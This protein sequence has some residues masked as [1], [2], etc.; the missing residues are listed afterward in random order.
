VA[1]LEITFFLWISSAVLCGHLCGDHRL[2][3][4]LS[5]HSFR[6]DCTVL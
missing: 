1:G 6:C 4:G 2:G 5:H 3:N